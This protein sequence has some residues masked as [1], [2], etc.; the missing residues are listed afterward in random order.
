MKGKLLRGIAAGTLIGAAAGML[1]IPQMDRR[2]RKRIERAGRKVMDFT[3]DMMDG[4]RS[5]RS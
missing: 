3:S 5:W 4:I 2:T 1:I